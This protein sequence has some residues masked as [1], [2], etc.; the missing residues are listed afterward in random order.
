MKCARGPGDETKHWQCLYCSVTVIIQKPS[1][2][3]NVIECNI[4]NFLQVELLEI[5]GSG[6]TVDDCCKFRILPLHSDHALG[7][8]A[9]T[10]DL[11][12]WT[13]VCMLGGMTINML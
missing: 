5:T 2:T 8:Q 6:D 11:N 10:I 4:F 13:Y 3:L 12:Y 9:C 7:N 1:V